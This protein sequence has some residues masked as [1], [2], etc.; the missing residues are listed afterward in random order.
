MEEI[1]KHIVLI[2][3]SVLSWLIIRFITVV[4]WNLIINNK[5]IFINASIYI[6]LLGILFLLLYLIWISLDKIQNN[7]F[8]DFWKEIENMNTDEL[9]S[10]ASW[11][12]VRFK[13][14]FKRKFT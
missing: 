11:T 4:Y 6:G 5:D 7:H 14:F 13:K 3:W 2:I 8:K 1:E 10:V 12:W 9:L